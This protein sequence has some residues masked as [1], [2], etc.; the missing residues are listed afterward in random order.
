M[1]N[2]APGK[3]LLHRGY[4]IVPGLRIDNAWELCIT[5]LDALPK[6]LSESYPSENVMED[7]VF[8]FPEQLFSSFGADKP[9]FTRI[10]RSL[11]CRLFR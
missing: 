3:G 4:M 5:H 10:R 2:E 9:R 11:L 1:P 8:V 7:K 6:T